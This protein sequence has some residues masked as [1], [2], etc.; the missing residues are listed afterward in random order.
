MDPCHMLK[1]CRNAFADK[2]MY[3][4]RGQIC[5]KYVVEL[6]KHQEELGFKYTNKLSSNNIFFKN[7]KM[8]VCL[9]TQTISSGVADAIDFLRE[10]GHPMFCDNQ[11]TT[12]FIRIFDRLFDMLNSRNAYGKGYKS[13][14]SLKN[15]NYWIEVFKESENYIRQLRLDG[16]IL[17]NTNRKVFAIGFIINIHSFHGLSLDLLTNI[18]N[19]LRY[20]L[21]YKCSQDHIELYFC[22][23]RSRCG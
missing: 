17:T 2:E 10:S 19:P 21:T 7:K 12:E 18:Q 23:I 5:F 6:H 14:L 13:L 4:P 8:K 20:F 9:A 16:K 1:L 11:A 3:S 15:M 22:C